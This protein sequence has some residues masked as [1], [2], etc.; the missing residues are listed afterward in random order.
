MSSEELV[1]YFNELIKGLK[2]AL[3]EQRGDGSRFRTYLIGR[4]FFAEKLKDK[5]SADEDWS[6]ILN[7]VSDVAK[8]LGIV[9]EV[10]F[11]VE[12]VREFDDLVVGRVINAVVRGC[13]HSAIDKEL[14]E[15]KVPPYVFCPIAN[16][17]MYVADEVKN[18]GEASSE[19]VTA[20]M[21]EKGCVLTICVFESPNKG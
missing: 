18:R 19:L 20:S 15:K 1:K 10:E 6:V 13:V 2:K 7:K 12:Y 8:N 14:V 3:Y 11:G 4:E 5:V 17:I 21:T 16:A 9:R